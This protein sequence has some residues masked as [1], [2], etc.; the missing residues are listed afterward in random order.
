MKYCPHCHKEITTLD[1]SAN[2]SEICYGRCNGIYHIDFDE[3]IDDD[4]YEFG[5]S[6]QD[7]TENYEETDY[8]YYCPECEKQLELEELLS[9]YNN[10]EENKKKKIDIILKGI[11]A[12]K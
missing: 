5:D 1:Y 2:F 12:N 8:E 7:N 11:L 9:E 4:E 10:E 6:S 3:E